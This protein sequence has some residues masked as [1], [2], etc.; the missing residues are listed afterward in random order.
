[1]KSIFLFYLIN[2][3]IG[4]LIFPLAMYLQLLG[5]ISIYFYRGIAVVALLASI[6]LLGAL[7]FTYKSKISSAHAIAITALLICFNVNFLVLVPVSLDRSI[8]VY[9]LGYSYNYQEPFTEQEL[10]SIFLKGY[11]ND[12]NAIARRIDEQLKSGNIKKINETQYQLTDRG[13]RFV[14]FLRWV[15]PIYGVSDE[16]VSP[17]PVL[18]QKEK[19]P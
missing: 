12:K 14:R 2:I 3:C 13:K 5:S 8:S 4:I 10:E 16:F 18:I 6:Q 11:M 7:F 17:K 15:A 19:T 1:M 9:L